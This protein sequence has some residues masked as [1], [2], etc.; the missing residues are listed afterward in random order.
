MIVKVV[1]TLYTNEIEC[2]EIVVCN[3]LQDIEN[4]KLGNNDYDDNFQIK[5][6]EIITNNPINLTN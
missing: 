2:A 1:Y 3:C 4:S 6:I 5:S